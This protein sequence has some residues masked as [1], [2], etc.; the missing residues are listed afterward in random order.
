MWCTD[1]QQINQIRKSILA[2]NKYINQT[3]LFV[4][5]ERKHW[6]QDREVEKIHVAQLRIEPRASGYVHQRSDH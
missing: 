3:I 4:P 2:V 6:Y 1:L 5:V